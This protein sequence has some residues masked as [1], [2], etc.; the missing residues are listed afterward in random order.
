MA[1]TTTTYLSNSVDLN[2]PSSLL[3]VVPLEELQHLQDSLHGVRGGF[4]RGLRPQS[5]LLLQHVLCSTGLGRMG[6]DVEA[7]AQNFKGSGV[8]ARCS[9]LGCWHGR[10]IPCS[11]CFQQA[12]NAA[13]TSES[14]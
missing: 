12:S 6:V 3:A 1:P 10:I 7:Q 13:P 4:Y 11:A 9:C 5:L 2:E 14:P 8:A